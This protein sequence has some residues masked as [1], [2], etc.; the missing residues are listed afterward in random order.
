MRVMYV[1]GVCGIVCVCVCVCHV[2]EAKREEEKKKKKWDYSNGIIS[3]IAGV[4]FSS[5]LLLFIC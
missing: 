1:C 4:Y 3:S 2:P 5:Y